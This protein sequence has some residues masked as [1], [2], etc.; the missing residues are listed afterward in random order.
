MN[1]TRGSMPRLT[2]AVADTSVSPLGPKRFARFRRR[3]ADE[4]QEAAAAAPMTTTASGNH[5][6][7]EG[8]IASK[9]P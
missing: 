1:L 6:R 4:L 9:T 3:G 7:L 5:Q 2:V 8:T